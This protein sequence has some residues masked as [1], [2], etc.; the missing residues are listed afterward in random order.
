MQFELYSDPS[1]SW[2]KVSIKKL[3]ELGI[4]EHISSYSYIKNG[5]AFLE[6]DKDLRTF[7][8][9][10]KRTGQSVTFTERHTNR[11]SKIRKYDSYDT[12]EDEFK[13]EFHRIIPLDKLDF[14]ELSNDGRFYEV[15]LKGGICTGYRLN[16]VKKG[17]SVKKFRS[18]KCIMY[19]PPYLE[20]K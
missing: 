4:T 20:I 16:G 10:M 9:A 14:I 8:E 15:H 17:P 3:L 11:S 12:Y 2:A 13:E 19:K 7:M 1:H 6:E 5:W 18:T